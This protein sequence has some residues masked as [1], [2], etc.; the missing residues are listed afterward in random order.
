[1]ALALAVL[2]NLVAIDLPLMD[3]DPTLYASVA[4]AMVRRGDYVGLYAWGLDW[5]DKPHLPFWLTAA[6]FRLFGVTVWAYRLPA[7]L[8]IVAAGYYTYR[9]AAR[10]TSR[11][12]GLWSATILLTAQHIV[13]SSADVRAEPYLTCFVVAATWYLIRVAEDERWLGPAVAGGLFAAAAVMTKGIFTVIPIAGALGGHW[14]VRGRPRIAW[15]RWALVALVTVLGITPELGALYFQFDRHPEKVVFGRT[16]VSGIR[17]FLWDSQFGRFLGTGP[18]RQEEWSPFYYFH[19]VLW[20]FLPWSFALVLAVGRRARLLWR[21]PRDSVEWYTISGAAAMFLVFSASKFQLPYYLNIVFPFLAIV[22][23][24]ELHAR[25]SG[26]RFAL[27]SRVQVGLLALLVAVGAT[28]GVLARPDGALGPTAVALALVASVPLAWRAARD[29]AVKLLLASV[30]TAVALNLYLER[31]IFP[32]LLWYDGGRR[33]AEYINERY[34]DVAVIVPRDQQ[35][36]GLDFGLRRPPRYLDRL[37]D[38]SQVTTRPYLLLV[39]QTGDTPDPGTVRTFDHF[40]VSR[41]TLPF[42]NRRTRA[43]TVARLDLV[44][45]GGTPPGGG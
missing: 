22:T 40:R 20:A 30:L 26:G 11:T 43:G 17:F 41:P 32:T 4:A 16:G 1:M 25:T 39:R 24:G 44:L 33:A 37:A 36:A 27:L 28:L 29:R 34:P 45:V 12:I 38:T 10:Y 3:D 9:L 42:V 21:G 7:F 6:S 35:F 13:L 31:G 2:V 18:I 5:L 23:A 19:T 14:L 8:A 15:G